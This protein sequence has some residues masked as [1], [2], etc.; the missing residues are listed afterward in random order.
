MQRLLEVKNDID[1]L[2]EACE[3]WPEMLRQKWS[4]ESAPLCG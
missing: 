3:L 4:V 1:L 2:Q